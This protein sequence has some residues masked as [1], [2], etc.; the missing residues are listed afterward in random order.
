MSRRRAKSPK[1]P[2]VTD[3]AIVRYL[4][5]AAGLDIDEVR[6]RILPPALEALA[7]KGGRGTF[8]IPGEEGMRAVIDN[9]VVVTVLG[10]TQK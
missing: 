2:G 7:R 5:R 1:A 8:P 3:H 10:G 4:E 9:G 6:R